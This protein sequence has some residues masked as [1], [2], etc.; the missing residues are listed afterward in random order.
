MASLNFEEEKTIFRAYYSDNVDHLRIAE[1]FFRSTTIALLSSLDC[2]EKPI[3]TSRVKDREECIRKFALKYQSDLERDSTNYEIKDFITD[4]IG[5][6]VVCLYEDEVEKVASLIKDNFEV[7]EESNKA[8]EIESTE[9]LFGY[10][11]FHL[12]LRV[13]GNRR[14][15]P[16]YDKFS[17]VRFEM[18]IRTIVQDAWSVLDH[19]IKYKKTIPASLKRRV[20]RLAALFELAD[21]E[22]LSIKN[23]L[24]KLEVDAKE[25]VG[26]DGHASEEALNDILNVFSF[27]AVA[28]GFFHGYDFGSVKADGFSQELIL[29]NPTISVGEFIKILDKHLDCVKEYRER[30]GIKPNPFTMIRHAIYLSDKDKYKSILFDLQRGNFDAYL[31]EIEEGKDNKFVENNGLAP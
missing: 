22:F 14:H 27:L 3:V 10:K 21:H 18:Q 26:E 1:K 30:K 31:N 15:F 13:H 11:G 4:L 16:E 23:S 19:K 9:N 29:L 25:A 17:N 8:E 7:I 24:R 5:V 28:Q 12:D 6:R 2:I 20:N